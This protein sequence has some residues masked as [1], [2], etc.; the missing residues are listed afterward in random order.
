MGFWA[1]HSTGC[2]VWVR[3]CAGNQ[4]GPAGGSLLAAG[5][6]LSA[7]LQRLRL[8]DT[9]AGDAGA[10]ALSSALSDAS[11]V[12]DLDLS[13]CGVT[14][15][16]VHAL[17]GAIAG[18]AQLQSL[19]L[20]RNSGVT[21]AGLAAALQQL[22][23]AGCGLT[24]LDLSQVPVAAAPAVLAALAALE[25]LRK[26]SLLGCRSSGPGGSADM[27][28]QLTDGSWPALRELDLCGNEIDAEAMAHL[29]AAVRSGAGPA[30][31]VRQLHGDGCASCKSLQRERQ[32]AVRFTT[33][34]YSVLL[35][36]GAAAGCQPWERCDQPSVCGG[37]AGRREGPAWPRRCVAGCR[38]R[39]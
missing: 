12:R 38:R 11:P 26:L 35:P 8:A 1:S 16:G 25:S 31:Q 14:D 4:L 19:A 27:A 24:E 18:G 10:A 20:S 33:V 37:G 39:P 32:G 7:T 6:A 22:P 9:A 34:R 15:E 23:A 2:Q 30:L 17:C 5:V 13:G 36:A 29:L 28:V 3:L 21:A